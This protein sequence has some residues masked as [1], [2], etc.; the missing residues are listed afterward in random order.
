MCK[1]VIH[2]KQQ[3]CQT[4][5]ETNWLFSSTINIKIWQWYSQQNKNTL[6]KML[7]CPWQSCS[8]MLPPTQASSLIVDQLPDMWSAL[9]W[10]SMLLSVA[11]FSH[12]AGAA[13]QEMSVSDERIL[14]FISWAVFTGIKPIWIMD[15]SHYLVVFHGC[16]SGHWCYLHC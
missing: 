13:V 1:I 10:S 4:A 9:E 14:Q 11:Y 3:I 8:P 6:E 2:S 5:A 7:L 12:K 16:N 15:I